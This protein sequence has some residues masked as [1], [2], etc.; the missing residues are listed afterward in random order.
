MKRGGTRAAGTTGHNQC[1]TPSGALPGPG[2]SVLPSV[3]SARS[4]HHHL[5]YSKLSFLLG[6]DEILQAD[7]RLQLSPNKPLSEWRGDPISPR[8]A[9]DA[10]VATT[11]PTPRSTTPTVQW[12][13]GLALEQGHCGL[14]P[15]LRRGPTWALRTNGSH[16]PHCHEKDT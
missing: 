3:Q 14:L 5:A 10:C 15:D 4:T 11:P 16:F 8:G 7:G 13:A 9:A 12:E 2:A 6:P 1:L